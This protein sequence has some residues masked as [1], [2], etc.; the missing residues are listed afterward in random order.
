MELATEVLCYAPVRA[1]QKMHFYQQAQ[2]MG[3]PIINI[4]DRVN[5]YDLDRSLPPATREQFQMFLRA[6]LDDKE[7]RLLMEWQ[8]RLVT[9][10]KTLK[11]VTEAKALSHKIQTCDEKIAKKIYEVVFR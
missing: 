10:Q 6:A 4:R 11:N 5:R 7:V 9:G 3:N 8:N 1:I 2:E